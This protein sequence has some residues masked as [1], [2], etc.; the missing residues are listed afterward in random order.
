M[1]TGTLDVSAITDATTAL[2]AVATELEGQPSAAAQLTADQAAVDGATAPLAA[3]VAAVQK[4]ASPPPPPPASLT[5]TPDPVGFTAGTAGAVGLTVT[6]GVAPY[7]LGGLPAGVT[8]DASTDTLNA[9]TTTV[10]GT[11]PVAVSDSSSPAV[12]GTVSVV[13]N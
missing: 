13:I 10:A 11:T 7:S 5:V 2:E 4:I 1:T 8:F 6:G 9:D 3:A 12:T